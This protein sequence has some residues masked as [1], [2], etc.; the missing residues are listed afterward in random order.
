MIR[1]KNIVFF[2]QACLI[3]FLVLV[4]GVERTGAGQIVSGSYSVK[5]STDLGTQVRVTLQFRLTNAGEQRL[6]ITQMSLQ[7]PLRPAQ[8]SE[9]RGTVILEPH[10]GTEVTRQFTIGKDEFKLMRQSTRPRVSLRI[11]GADGTETTV[12]LSLMRRAG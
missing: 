1:G 5:E 9:D 12:T 2:T 11:Q 8:V 6:F 4:L 7:N 3:L 10:K